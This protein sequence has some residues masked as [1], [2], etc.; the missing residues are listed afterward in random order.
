MAADVYDFSST[1]QSKILSL[2]WRD[3]T[4]YALYQEVIKPKY[5]ESEIHI[6]LARIILNFYEKYETPPTLEAMFEEVRTLCTSSKVKKEKFKDYVKEVD[7]L[8]DMDLT[9]MEYVKDKIVEF[10]RR[11][12][13]TQAIFD[14]IDDVKA[15]KN[16]EKVEARIKEA[17]QVGVDLGDMGMDYFEQIDE[18]VD[19]IYNKPDAE[20]IP[21]GVELLDVI[22][23]GGLG[24]KELGIVIAP[25]G[26]GKTLTL[27]NI[28]ASAILKG[29]NVLHLTLE[30]SE[31]RI[32][33]R[34]DM[35]FTEKTS[36]YIKGNLDAVK[37]SLHLISK[38][39]KGKLVIKEFAPRTCSPDTIKSLITK[40]RISKNFVP[41][42]IIID[43]P[44]LMKPARTYGE[45]RTE[46]EILYEDVRAL[47]S[48]FDCAVWGA[49][50]T[51]RAALSK[52]VV[53]IGDLAEAFGKAAVA[54]FMMALSQTK[55]EK[56]AGEVRYYIA[57]HRNGQDNETVCCDIY[58]DKMT[59][60]SNE[61][62]Q[63]A[64]EMEDH[65]DDD[66]F[67]DDNDSGYKKKT[68]EKKKPQKE[69]SNKDNNSSSSVTSD[70]MG[71]IGKDK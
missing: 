61:E 8:A 66:D 11:Q 34:Y 63:A 10:G 6:D 36:D 60:K 42:V 22:M 71:M 7:V 38:H 35:K 37:K 49:S 9:D 29:K 15:G 28:G 67:D 5:F 13:L 1:F 31:E 19:E 12:A 70:V 46:L 51:N 50:Q 43:Y 59:V 30:M 57:K 2:L 25:P 39:R 14:S 54:D 20:K 69:W 17:N 68:Y 21:T 58:Y 52:K 41:D 24:R 45:R 62:R 23:K 55:K 64:F 18:R 33:Q 26:S 3:A 44:D 48:L 47:G 4:C 56:R 32:S 27:I 53:T 65:D 40:L 16:F